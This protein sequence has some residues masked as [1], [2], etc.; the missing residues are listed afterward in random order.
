MTLG[1]VTTRQTPQYRE[2]LDANPA[3]F[4]MLTTTWT[5]HRASCSSVRP[6]SPPAPGARVHQE[7]AHCSTSLA[8]LE[9]AL[10]QIDGAVHTCSQCEPGS[11][12]RGVAMMLTYAANMRAKVAR[13]R[14]AGLR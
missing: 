13:E 6:L 3:G 14:R 8:K 12:S 11:D 1:I 7:D 2:W 5:I 4:V 9:F 10:L